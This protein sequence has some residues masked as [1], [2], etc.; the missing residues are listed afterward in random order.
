MTNNQIYEINENINNEQ[1]K[2]YHDID[3]LPKLLK[4]RANSFKLTPKQC[5]ELLPQ[6]I[7]QFGVKCITEIIFCGIYSIK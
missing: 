2:L 4:Y 7:K 6:F 5:I 1:E 3:I